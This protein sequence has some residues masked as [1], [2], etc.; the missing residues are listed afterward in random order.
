MHLLISD[1]PN[2]NIGADTYDLANSR[3]GMGMW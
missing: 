1:I 2:I 3:K